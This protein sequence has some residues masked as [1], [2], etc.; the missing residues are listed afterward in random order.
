MAR[1]EY[2]TVDVFTSDRFGGNPLAVFPEADSVP[3][4]LMPRIAN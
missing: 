3:P 4:E 2:R 1:H